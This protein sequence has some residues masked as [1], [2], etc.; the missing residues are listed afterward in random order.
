MVS[1]FTH[2]LNHLTRTSYQQDPVRV[3]EF[4]MFITYQLPVDECTSIVIN[5]DY[6]LG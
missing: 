3:Y 5:F 1:N 6:I 2:L 4:I